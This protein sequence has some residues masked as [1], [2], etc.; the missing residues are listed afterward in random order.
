MAVTSSAQT[1]QRTPAEQ[2]A[3]Y[4][5]RDHAN[6]EAM[7]NLVIAEIASQTAAAYETDNPYDEHPPDFTM[8]PKVRHLISALQSAHGGGALPF[9]EFT[10]DYLTIGAQLQFTGTDSAIRARVRN[11]VDTLIAWQL[12][13]GYDLLS[14]VKGGKIIGHEADGTPIRKGSTFID[15]LK[16]HCDDGV[17]RARDSDLWRGNEALDTKAHPGRALAAQVASVVKALPRIQPDNIVCGEKVWPLP[18]DKYQQRIEQRR[19]S[20]GATATP[21]CGSKS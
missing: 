6:I 19:E 18:R 3:R 14:V 4:R 8:P 11:W 9:E 13:V 15:N 21:I 5:R 16:P 1:Q 2:R 17:M 10:R 20:K 12:L 7:I